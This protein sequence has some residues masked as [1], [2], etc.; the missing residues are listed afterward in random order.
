[1]THKA[2]E[3]G[4]AILDRD[5]ELETEE[6]FGPVLRAKTSVIT[7]VLTTQA[8]VDETRLRRQTLDRLPALMELVNATAKRLP[9]LIDQD[10]AAPLPR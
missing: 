8:K 3:Q 5:L 4:E 2:L 9:P 6:T 10:A 1:M 7:S